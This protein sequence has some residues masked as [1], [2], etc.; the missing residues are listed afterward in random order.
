MVRILDT[1]DIAPDSGLWDFSDSP[2]APKAGMSRFRAGAFWQEDDF[3]G[4]SLMSWNGARSV[5]TRWTGT[6]TPQLGL[7]EV[8]RVKRMDP[9]E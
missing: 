5:A 9:G 8:S 1:S 3:Y 6:C 7:R 2:G 4:M